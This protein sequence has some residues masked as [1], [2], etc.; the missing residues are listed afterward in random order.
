VRDLAVDQTIKCK[1]A[2]C[3]IKR[4]L[5]DSRPSATKLLQEPFVKTLLQIMDEKSPTMDLNR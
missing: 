2:A 4:M 1:V 5:S 3:F